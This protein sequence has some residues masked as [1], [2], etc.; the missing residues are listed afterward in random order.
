MSKYSV[1]TVD[2]KE[3]GKKENVYWEEEK[4][5]YGEKLIESIQKRCA[6]RFGGLVWKVIPDTYK[7]GLENPPEPAIDYD[8]LSEA[9]S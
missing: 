1:I 2:N 9:I 6:D 4:Y 5:Y 3:T 7:S 8:D